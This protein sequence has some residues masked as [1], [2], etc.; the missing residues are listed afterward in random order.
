MHVYFLYIA[1]RFPVLWQCYI[2]NQYIQPL[3]TI[4]SIR[5]G[6]LVSAAPCSAPSSNNVNRCLPPPRLG[7]FPILLFFVCKLFA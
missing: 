4:W 7:P 2:H 3:A 5:S 6:A 1:L